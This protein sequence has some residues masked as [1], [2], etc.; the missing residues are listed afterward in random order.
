M[1]PEGSGQEEG[2]RGQV[3]L[4]S[5]ASMVSLLVVCGRVVRDVMRCCVS[6]LLA[7]RMCMFVCVYVWLRYQCA[8]S[9]ALAVRGIMYVSGF[10]GPPAWS[11]EACPPLNLRATSCSGVC[12]VVRRR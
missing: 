8:R 12:S 2:E 4:D 6:V 1:Q 11:S 7:M 9:L 5:H 10:D 3:A